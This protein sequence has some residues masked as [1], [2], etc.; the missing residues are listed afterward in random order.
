M[1]LD[2]TPDFAELFRVAVDVYTYILQYSIPFAFAFGI[3]NVIV[4]T[5]LSVAFGGRLKIGGK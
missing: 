2:N 3:G 5:L 4:N 1:M